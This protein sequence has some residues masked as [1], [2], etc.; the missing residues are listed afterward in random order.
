MTTLNPIVVDL[1]HH[2]YDD[3]GRALNF[4]QAKKWGVR[5]VIYK[6]TEGLTNKDPTYDAMRVLATKAGILWGAYHFL[7]P[8][9]PYTQAKHFVDTAKPVAGT[10][11]V[12]DHEDS[13]CSAYQAESF[14]RSLEQ[15]IKR[16]PMLYTYD[17]FIKEQL[18]NQVHQYFSG[19]RLWI[20]KYGTEPTCQAT[21][22]N[23]WLWQFTGDGQGPTPHN[24]P[25]LGDKIDINHWPGT[26]DDLV[27]EWALGPGAEKDYVP[28]M[29]ELSYWGQ[30]SLN[31][32]GEADLK[33]DGAYGIVTKT[34]VAKYQLNRNLEITNQLDQN[35]IVSLQK[36]IAL[37]N[38]RRDH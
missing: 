16:R 6:A 38:A 12:C 11:M 13:N 3:N 22:D 19:C 26:Y 20:A 33:I 23:Y 37:W 32:I 21:W 29:K 24:I 8:G 1:S 18:G 30:A 35:T 4:E 28:T 34:A 2:N 17:S 9:D 25:G 36:D 5:G 27:D 15:I 7:R 10:L 31:L 14:M